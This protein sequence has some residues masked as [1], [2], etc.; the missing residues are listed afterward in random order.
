MA[1]SKISKL[2]GQQIVKLRTAKR[3]SQADLARLCL[4]DRQSIE[5]VENG[6]T[7]PTVEYL[8]DIAEALDVHIKELFDFEMRAKPDKKG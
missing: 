2:L 3:L 4:R 8:A 6:K 7:N 1:N 5:R